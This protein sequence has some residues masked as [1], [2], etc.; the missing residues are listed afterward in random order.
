MNRTIA[1]YINCKRS[2]LKSIQRGI[3]RSNEVSPLFSNS[4]PV[5]DV[6]FLL[7]SPSVKRDLSWVNQPSCLICIFSTRSRG[8]I[9]RSDRS[10]RDRTPTR[11]IPPFTSLFSFVGS[12]GEREKYRAVTFPRAYIGVV[13]CTFTRTDTP[14]FPS[15]PQKSLSPPASE[16]TEA[17][18]L[19]ANSV[20]TQPD[21]MECGLRHGHSRSLFPLPLSTRVF[22]RSRATRL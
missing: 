2:F 8:R 6:Q 12:R 17:C 15:G 14:L 16:T 9:I 7:G 10:D 1:A 20:R 19:L 18:I 4:L 13:A 5:M 21:N 3:H 22:A 11:K